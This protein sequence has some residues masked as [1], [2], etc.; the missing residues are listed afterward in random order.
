M[1][2]KMVFDDAAEFERFQK[3]YNSYLNGGY[4]EQKALALTKEAFW[5]TK[6]LT[7]EERKAYDRYI[8]EIGLTPEEAYILASK[9]PLEKKEEKEEKKE[10]VP[11]V[12]HW[13]EDWIN[14]IEKNWLDTFKPF[15][16]FFDESF[17]KD[18]G[19][20]CWLD[21]GREK[22]KNDNCKCSCEKKEEKPASASAPAKP[23]GAAIVDD[24]VKKILNMLPK[25]EVNDKNTK[26]NIIKSEPNDWEFK[27]EHNSPDGR[28][29]YFC[30]QKVVKS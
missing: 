3:L 28:C 17:F 5:P 12:K 19:A 2:Q 27:V 24:E 8:F 23:K 30:S 9:K 13:M 15:N 25:E 11:A 20:P 26:V 18:F 14:P 29:H 22:K 1:T 21:W 16:K 7:E 4:S 10:E 6:P